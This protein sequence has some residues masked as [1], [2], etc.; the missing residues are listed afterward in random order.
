MGLKEKLGREAHVCLT[1][2]QL[3]SILLL[4]CKLNAASMHSVCPAQ[5][6][7][8]HKLSSHLATLATPVSPE[9]LLPSLLALPSLFLS[10]H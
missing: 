1:D 4:S 10:S 8:K 6:S 7:N 3:A 9:I 5:N 2:L